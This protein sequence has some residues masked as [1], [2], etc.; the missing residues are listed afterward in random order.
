MDESNRRANPKKTSVSRIFPYIVWSRRLIVAK[1]NKSFCG[2]TQ[3]VFWKLRVIGRSRVSN[4]YR[5]R[6]GLQTPSA[7]DAG[8][9]TQVYFCGGVFNH[10]QA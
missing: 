5:G 7:N 6:L 9:P 2:T 1:K 8:K 10:P 3:I 4:R